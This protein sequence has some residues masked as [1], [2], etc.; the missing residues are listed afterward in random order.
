MLRNCIAPVAREPMLAKIMRSSGMR[1]SVTL[2]SHAC[3]HATS[4]Q[5]HCCVSQGNTSGN[6]LS[7]LQAPL[8]LLG[9]LYQQALSQ[10]SPE[11]QSTNKT[12]TQAN[13]FFFSSGA[14]KKVFKTMPGPFWPLFQ[15]LSRSVA[16]LDPI[17]CPQ[18]SSVLV[19]GH[20]DA[21][22][23]SIST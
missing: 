9:F 17:S 6:V 12:S 19:A 3:E 22:Q 18:G 1:A 21:R 2:L 23:I 11:K 7:L 4:P 16:T 10:V 15:P 13:C 20:E 5:L 14:Q 8:S